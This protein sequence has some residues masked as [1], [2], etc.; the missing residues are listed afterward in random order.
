MA[1]QISRCTCH[2]RDFIRTTVSGDLH[3]E[4]SKKALAA[5]LGD[6]EAPSTYDILLDLREAECDLKAFD[7]YDIVRFLDE[8][9]GRPRGKIAVLVAGDQHLMTAKFMELC[10]ENRG[11]RA[12]AFTELAEAEGWLGLPQN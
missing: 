12:H 1:A 7:V 2:A 6:P 11:L 10:A 5:L 8:A 9:P 3:L 4:E